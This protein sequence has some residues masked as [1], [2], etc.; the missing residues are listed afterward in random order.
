MSVASKFVTETRSNLFSSSITFLPFLYQTRSLSGLTPAT[1]APKSQAVSS[2]PVLRKL[3]TSAKQSFSQ[4]NR[5]PNNS[6]DSQNQR[7]RPPAQKYNGRHQG[8]RS[9]VG[10]GDEEIAFEDALDKYTGRSRNTRPAHDTSNA[11]EEDAMF[12]ESDFRD[13]D[14]DLDY[15]NQRVGHGS[16]NLPGPRESTITDSERRAFQNIFA[17]MFSDQKHSTKSDPDTSSP[18]VDAKQSLDS[19]LSEALALNAQNKAKKENIVNAWPGALRPAVAKA[20]GLTDEDTDVMSVEDNEGD[21]S[22]ADEQVDELESSREPERQRV[23]TLMRNAKTDVDLW[24]V[25]DREVFSLVP[26]LGL[27]EKASDAS[28][29]PATKKKQKAPKPNHVGRYIKRENR[30]EPYTPL[31]ITDAN[32]TTAPANRLGNVLDPATGNEIPAL[33]FYGPLYP[34][35]LL[36]GIRLLDREFAKPSP[37]ALSVLPKIKS[38]GAISHV[39]GAS[40]ALYNEI[41]HIYLYRHQDLQSMTATL[42][43]MYA[44]AVPANRE[45]LAIIDEA[46][47]LARRAARGTEGIPTQQLWS[48]VPQF[49][50]KKL[51]DWRQRIINGLTAQA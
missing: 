17:E 5:S 4:Q 25:M 10:R 26:R 36:L 22:G 13:D 9:Q 28:T 46:L 40:P 12:N 31:R 39:L 37:L 41:L 16:M 45:S 19:I 42:K 11:P 27:D 34:S 18:K 20:I 48:V 21:K 3:S 1:A 43:D 15:E 49:S 24:D 47:R 14:E 33:A 44:S 29:K 38:L 35:Y 32:E 23:D 6:R 2:R 50:T 51:F 8:S 30:Q 7:S